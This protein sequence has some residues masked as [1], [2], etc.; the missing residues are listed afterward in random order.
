MKHLKYA[1]ITVLI[2]LSLPMLA[3]AIPTTTYRA[4]DI[5][6][7]YRG[8]SYQHNPAPSY[9][10]SPQHSVQWYQGQPRSQNSY[11]KRP[12]YPANRPHISVVTPHVDVYIQSQPQTHYQ[13][14]EEVYLPYGGNYRSVTEYVPMYSSPY[15]Q[16]RVV[17]QGHY[18]SE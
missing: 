16:N 18:Y 9:E 8:Y 14:T 11:P 13:R 2:P 12:N 3:H 17:I 15:G 7:S 5:H 10:Y 6:P 1:F 4:V